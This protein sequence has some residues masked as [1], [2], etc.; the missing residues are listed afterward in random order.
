MGD[1]SVAP[2]FNL[3]SR[4][5]HGLQKI[6]GRQSLTHAGNLEAVLG[7]TELKSQG[8]ALGFEP[9]L[10]KFFSPELQGCPLLRGR[11]FRKVHS[12]PLSKR[13][14]PITK[15]PQSVLQ[16]TNT[17]LPDILQ[18]PPIEDRRQSERIGEGL[19]AGGQTARI[20]ASWSLR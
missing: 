8:I 9:D 5:G 3:L 13:A 16:T 12:D 17:T 6:L 10:G 20:S 1:A 2:G 7:D 18:A 15:R 11:L 14:S 19:G 4:Y